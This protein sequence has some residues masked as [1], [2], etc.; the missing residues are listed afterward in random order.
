ML[1]GKLMLSKLVQFLNADFPIVSPPQKIAVLRLV[2][3]S[4]ADSPMVVVSLEMLKLSSLVQFLKANSGITLS[5]A[6]IITVSRDV[7]S[8][9]ADTPIVSVLLGIVIVFRLVHPEKA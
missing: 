6:H 5:F 3:P 4:N 9:K 2:Q 7:Q 8:S 1:E